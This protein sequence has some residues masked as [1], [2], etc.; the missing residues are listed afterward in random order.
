MAYV[1][2]QACCNDASRVSACCIHPVPGKREYAQTEMLRIDPETCIAAGPASTLAQ[3]IFPEDKL[4][5]SLAR[6]KDINA[7]YYKTHPMPEGWIPLTPAT[8]PRRDLG[9][10]R[11][12]VVGTGRLLRGR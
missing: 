4:L 1:I 2:T 6:Y 7:D 11:I 9:T 5:G 3:A 8:P 12:A 10:L